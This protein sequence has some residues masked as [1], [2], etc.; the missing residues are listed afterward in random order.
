MTLPNGSTV[1]SATMFAML[2]TLFT[3][4]A[5][6]TPENA[7]N[8]LPE[9]GTDSPESQARQIVNTL[10][11]SM[12]LLPGIN[13]FNPP[14]AKASQQQRTS[15]QNNSAPAQAI[16]FARL[17]P[18][19]KPS[20]SNLPSSHGSTSSAGHVMSDGNADMGGFT[21]PNKGGRASSTARGQ[22]QTTSSRSKVASS[23]AHPASEPVHHNNTMYPQQSVRLKYWAQGCLKCR[24]TESVGWRVKQT[25]KKALDGTV[26][27]PGML[28][29]DD[30]VCK[31]CEGTFA[32][33]PYSAALGHILTRLP[34]QSRGHYR[35]CTKA[36]F[37]Q[38]QEETQSEHLYRWK[39]HFRLVTNAWT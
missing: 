33:I 20:A 2:Q 11:A 38:E 18:K 21:F 32:Y 17:R 35:M 23:S 4:T 19:A 26:L 31:L 1:D 5:N 27:E 25:R 9:A 30:K 3:A 37:S 29:E 28:P 22:P 7:G 15:A 36:A 12:P 6:S 14:Q 8:G 13:L 10:G 34:T 16:P 24:K 39:Y